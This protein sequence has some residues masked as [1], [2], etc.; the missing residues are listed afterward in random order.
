VLQARLLLLVWTAFLLFAS[1][2]SFSSAG[3]GH[4]FV[5]LFGVE[6]PY[7]LHVLVRKLAHVV[8]YGIEGLL[9]LRATGRSRIAILIAVT[10]A[11]MDEVHQSTTMS[12]TGSG[13]DVLLD[14]F[15]ATVAVWA[16]NKLQRPAR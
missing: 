1:G 10:V 3:T 16:A 5:T 6:I 13:W 9:A 4:A 12:R 15:G 2:D 14:G 11:I 8:V 7:V